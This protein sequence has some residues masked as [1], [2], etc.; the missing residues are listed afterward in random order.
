MPVE[1]KPTHVI[2]AK[3]GIEPGGRIHKYFTE[4]CAEY[5]DA[6][7]PYDRGILAKY[8]IEDADKIV[9]D[10]EYAK[11]QYYGQRRDGTHVINPEN[12]NRSKHPLA[13]SYWDKKMVTAHMPDIIKEV[14]EEIKRGGGR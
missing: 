6:Y 14:Q 10:Q 8:H 1:L 3:L 2:A 13:T 11:Y 7:V 12:R 5:M 4:R 9:Y